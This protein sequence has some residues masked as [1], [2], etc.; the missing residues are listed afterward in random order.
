MAYSE[1]TYQSGLQHTVGEELSSLTGQLGQAGE[2]IAHRGREL[3]RQAQHGAEDAVRER[4]LA[5]LIAAAVIGFALG[6]LW[7]L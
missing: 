6:A 4:P 7:K 2:D 5:M 3:T 1:R